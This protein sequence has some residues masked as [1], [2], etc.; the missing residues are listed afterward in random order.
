V[1]KYEETPTAESLDLFE[2][3]RRANVRLLRSV[4][5]ATLD[6]FGMH[7]ERGRES[8][9]HLIRLYAGHDLN[10]VRQIE[11]LLGR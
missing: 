8:V 2:V 7:A 6:H 1:F 11:A 5:P 4:D 10:H 9:T 3:S